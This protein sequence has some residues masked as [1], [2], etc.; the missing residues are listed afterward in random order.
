MLTQAQYDAIT[1]SLAASIEA[2]LVQAANDHREQVL[3]D[4]GIVARFIAN[5][6]WSAVLKMVPILARVALSTILAR[7]GEKTVND[8]MDLIYASKANAITPEKEA[9]WQSPGKS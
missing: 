7:F 2:P 6:L 8:I 1:D 5:R 4:V 9:T 3:A